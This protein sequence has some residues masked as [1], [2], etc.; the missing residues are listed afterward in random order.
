MTAQPPTLPAP[1]LP[2][3]RS[4]PR[5]PH[6]VMPLRISADGGEA[7]HEFPEMVVEYRYSPAYRGRYERG[8]G[9][10]LEPD[11][12][13]SVEI[14]ACY[15]INAKTGGHDPV[16]EWQIEALGDQIEAL[17][18]QA[19]EDGVQAGKEAAAEARY[20]DRLW[21]RMH[22]SHAMARE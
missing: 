5:R 14:L 10:Q 9:I 17:C 8:G 16:P 12:P 7:E 18:L 4:L 1:S 21:E 3:N 6:I 20:E 2:V 22:G 19:Y 15:V 11:E 13:A